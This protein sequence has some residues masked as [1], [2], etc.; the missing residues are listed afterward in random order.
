MVVLQNEDS[1]PKKGKSTFYSLQSA[2]PPQGGK[3][4]TK[5]AVGSWRPPVET[6]YS[7]QEPGSARGSAKGLTSQLERYLAG[8]AHTQSRPLQGAVVGSV[9]GPKGK[10]HYVSYVSPVRSGDQVEPQT[11]LGGS[12]STPPRPNIDRLL[13]KAASNHQVPNKQLS[14]VDERFIQN[15]VNQLGRQRVNMDGLMGKDLNQ[16]ADIISEA[17][18]VVDGEG[19]GARAKPRVMAPIRDRQMKR[20][21]LPSKDQDEEDQDDMLQDAR[22]QGMN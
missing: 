13:F 9:V 8:A 15:V 19:P 21:P 3:V 20:E 1:Q 11:R 2:E 14:T 5:G 4:F 16:L 6:A 18:H 10:L 22:L 17:L 12:G 7:S